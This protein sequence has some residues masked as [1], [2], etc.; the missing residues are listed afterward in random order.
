MVALNNICLDCAPNKKDAH[1]ERCM[2]LTLDAMERHN[3]E[4]SVQEWGCRLLITL[5]TKENTDAY[6]DRLLPLVILALETHPTSAPVCM[7]AHK[8]LGCYN[9]MESNQSCK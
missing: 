5:E 9:F 2:S 6:Q 3:G 1:R 7:Y 4:P 8:A